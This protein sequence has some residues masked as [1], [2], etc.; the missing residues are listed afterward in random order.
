MLLMLIDDNGDTFACET[1]LCYSYTNILQLPLALY[2]NMLHDHSLKT[3]N[4][5]VIASRSVSD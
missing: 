3:R 2:R 4:R 5:L 1:A